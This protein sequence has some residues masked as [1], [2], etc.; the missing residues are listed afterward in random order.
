MVAFVIPF[1]GGTQIDME[2]VQM[3]VFWV[4]LRELDIAIG[5]FSSQMMKPKLST[6]G[7]FV[8]NMLKVGAFLCKMIILNGMV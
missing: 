4:L 2:Y 7:V 6:L 8:A 1:R 3:P 5:G